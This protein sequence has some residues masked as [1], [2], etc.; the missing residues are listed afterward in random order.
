MV[1]AE[2][3]DFRQGPV[4]FAPRLDA[5][6]FAHGDQRAF[7]FDDQSDDL[8]HAPAVFE[9]AAAFDSFDEMAEARSWGRN[10]RQ[11]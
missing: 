6:D 9:E 1:V 10:G 7:G 5:A 3:D 4:F 11:F 2:A 8:F